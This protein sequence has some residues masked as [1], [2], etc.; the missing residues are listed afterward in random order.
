MT[1]TTVFERLALTLLVA[2]ASACST[3]AAEPAASPNVDLFRQD[4]LI[5]WCIVPFDAKKRTPA[6][7]AEMLQRLGFSKFAYDWRAEH[8]PTFDDE[9]RELKARN[10]EFSALWFPRAMNADAQL[11]LGSLEKHGI[12]TQFWVTGGGGPAN[13]PEEQRKQVEAE[14][15]RIRPIAEAA[16]KIGCTVGLYNHGGWFGEPENQL[17]IIEELK[18]PNVGIVYNQHHGHDHL[19]RFPQLLKKMMPHLM[20]LNLNGMEPAGDKKGQK[21]IPLGQGSLDLDLLK[22]IVASGYR[23]PIGILGHTQDDAEERLQDNLDGLHWLVPQ[24]TGKAPGPKPTPRTY[25]AKPATGA[26]TSTGPAASAPGYLAAGRDEY[27]KPPITVNCRATLKGKSGYNILLASDSKKS[28]AHWEL[29]TMPATGALTVYLPGSQPDHVRSQVDIADGKP[30]DLTMVYEPQRVR[31]IVDGKLAAEQAIKSK[32]NSAAPG[33]LAFTRLVEGGLGC[34][35]TLEFVHLRRGAHEASTSATAPQ[36]SADTIGLWIFDKPEQEQVADLSPAKNPAK[37]T[38]TAAPA[39]QSSKAPVPPPGVQLSGDKLKVTLIDRSPNDVYMAIKADSAGRLF[40]GGR[41]AVY[42]FEPTASGY[43]PRQELLRFPQDSIIIGLEL[44]GDDLYVLASSALYRVPSGRTQRKDLKPERILWGLP[45]DLHVSFHCLAWGPQGDL[46]LD[47]GDPLLGYG[48]WTR[49]DHWG[50]WTLYAGKGAQSTPY[51]GQGSVLRVSPL[52][53]NPR[54]VATGLR[55]PVGLTFDKHW[56]LF[57]NDNDHESRADQ[58]APARLLHVTPHIDFAWP[59]GW[60]AS[61]SV[62]RNDLI[63]PLGPDLGRGVP[64]D[65]VYYDEPLLGEL[66]GQ[67]LMCRWDRSSVTAYA[68]E[69]RGASFTSQ[70]TTILSGANNARPVGIAVDGNGRL[71]VTSLYMAGNMAAPY[72]YSDLVMVTRADEPGSKP[73]ES[74]DLTKL[75]DEKLWAELSHAAWLRRSWAHQEILRRG[76]SMLDKV[77]DKLAAAPE[78]DP[79]LPHLIWLATAHASAGDAAAIAQRANHTIAAIRL[80][81]IRALTEFAPSPA[82]DAVFTA[83]VRDASPE[84]QLAALAGWFK[85]TGE[86]PLI[87]VIRLAGSDDTYLR[88][89]ASLLLARRATIEQLGAMANSNDEPTR[90]AGVLAAGRR[91][92]VPEVDDR[93]PTEVALSYPKQGSFFKTQ[94][95]FWGETQDI[96]LS[97]LGRVGSYTTAQRWAATP[98]K[99]SAL[100]MRDLLLGSLKDSSDRVRMQAGYWLWLLKD[101]ECDGL[102]SAMRYGRILARLEK[103][104]QTKVDRAWLASGLD[105]QSRVAQSIESEPIDLTAQLHKETS[106]GWQAIQATEQRFQLS[107]AASGNKACYLYFKVSSGSRQMAM[108][109]LDADCAT[110]VWLSGVE[111]G[112]QTARR[113]ATGPNSVMLDLQPGGNDVLVRVNGLNSTRSIGLKFRAESPLQ[114]S[115]PEKLDSALLAE[116]LRDAFAGGTAQPVPEAFLSLDWPQ[117]AKQGDSSQGRRLFGALGCVKCHAITADQKGAGAPSLSEARRRFTVPHLVESILAP[118]KQIAEPFRAS[119]IITSDGKVLTGLIT[120]ETADQVELLTIDAARRKIS[121]VDIEERKLSPLSPMPPGLVKTPQELRD[122]L[123]YLTSERPLPP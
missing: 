110:K 69:P 87:D 91:L 106:P 78:N 50:H 9:L 101:S 98:P 93:P 62:D 73:V 76:G 67:L 7:R 18:L 65:M 118:S 58:Y 45:L 49:P 123:S 77:A 102:V 116:R 70:E 39:A 12:K 57:S 15:A 85:S 38:T 90:L 28:G 81:V 103:A 63:E 97:Q 25:K 30:H 27:R 32:G 83:G 34:N 42:V 3:T 96:D 20:V 117:E 64:C 6:Q 48:D 105:P 53:E 108:L 100:A 51:T 109:D 84:V 37:R 71:F 4:N 94:L 56:N 31:L 13:T 26:T 29:F 36:P 55:G 107:D 86:L 88:Q 40:V 35:G 41:E 122:L 79:R 19:E 112:E 92:T 68:V 1:R 61:K 44:R 46:F 66:R 54:V 14:A 80:Q 120:A 22:V 60:M 113:D 104:P 47:H 59:R 52:G 10:V 89:T 121:K 82:R 74:F 75:S 5:A 119:S 8:L 33:E 21:I 72:C 114:T 95:R 24:L 99:P 16:A 111:A 2:L 43:G 11:L 115:L 23:G 17:A